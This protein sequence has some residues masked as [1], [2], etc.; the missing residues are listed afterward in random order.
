MRVRRSVSDSTTHSAT[1]FYAFEVGAQLLVLG[2]TISR[3]VEVICACC[4]ASVGWD[5]IV[6]LGRLLSCWSPI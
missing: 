6:G 4:G 5:D 3:G 1:A 2:E